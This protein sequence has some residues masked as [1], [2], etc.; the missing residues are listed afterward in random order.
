SGNGVY[1]NA[2]ASALKKLHRVKVVTASHVE[3]T[4]PPEVHPVLVSSKRTLEDAG[5]VEFVLKGLKEVEALSVFNPSLALGID[6]HSAPICTA[7]AKTCG[8]KFIFMPF[9]IFSYSYK[10][11]FIRKLEELG[12][13]YADA[14]IALSEVDARL[15]KEFFGR[16]AT[17]INPPV[18]VQGLNKKKRDII[19]TISRVSPEKRIEK[20]VCA[21]PKVDSSLSLVIAGHIYSEPYLRELKELS[22]K[23]GVE[24]RVTFT[25]SLPQPQLW[26]LYSEAKIYVSPS[27][28]EPFGLSIAEA[29]AL[30]LPVIMDSSGMVGAGELLEDKKS[31]LKVDV[32]NEEELADAINLLA[33]NPKLSKRIGRNARKAALKLSKSSFSA[34]INKFIWSIVNS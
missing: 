31:C 21:L 34:E 18:N 14:I 6:W 7:L 28:Y 19:L 15:M 1:A 12:A 33:R 5:N 32:S 26:K 16:T 24:N 8:C 22:I 3:A 20:L 4:S 10:S 25:G 13:N 2:V 30:G 17:I 11:I 9:R 23:L 27:K 29:A